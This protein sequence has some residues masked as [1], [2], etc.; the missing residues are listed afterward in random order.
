MWFARVSQFI[1]QENPQRQIK[2]RGAIGLGGSPGHCLPGTPERSGFA[3]SAVERMQG[4]Y[5]HTRP[6]TLIVFTPAGRWQWDGPAKDVC[7]S[8]RRRPMIGSSAAYAIA[9]AR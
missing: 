1:E 9:S 4:H 8:R 6:D 2:D 3:R 5:W 7:S